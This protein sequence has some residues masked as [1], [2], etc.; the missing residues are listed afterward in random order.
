MFVNR[1]HFHSVN[2]QIICDAKMV[3]I[4]VV[5]KW[6]VSTHDSFILSQSSV[7]RKLQAGGF[8]VRFVPVKIYVLY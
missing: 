4:N 3:L 1:K 6:P 7:G 8:L 2:V 5:A